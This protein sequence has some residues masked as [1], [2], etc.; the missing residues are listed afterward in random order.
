MRKYLFIVFISLFIGCE[1]SFEI[2]DLNINTSGL[3][4]N[5]STGEP[6]KDINV[7]IQIFTG[8]GWSGGGSYVASSSRTNNDGKYQL[9]YNLK[10][11]TMEFMYI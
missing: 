10:M 6:I 7:T 11:I 1:N 2:E 4:I 3:V 9:V 8:S 5:E